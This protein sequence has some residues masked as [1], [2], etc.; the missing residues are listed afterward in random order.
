MAAPPSHHSSHP[1]QWAMTVAGH[2]LA[3]ALG[4]SCTAPASNTRAPGDFNAHNI[5][6][7]PLDE[8]ERNLNQLLHLVVQ[9]SSTRNWPDME[10]A[11]ADATQKLRL[12]LELNE[13]SISTAVDSYIQHKVDQLMRL[14]SFPPGLN[15]VY[16]RMMNRVFDSDDVDIY[17]EVLRLVSIVHRPLS[18]VELASLVDSLEDYAD[19]AASPEEIVVYFGHQP[20]KDFLLK[21]ESGIHPDGV[22]R[23][24]RAAALKSIQVM[25]RTPR[26]DISNLRAPGFPIEQVKPL[27]PDLL[28]PARYSRVYWVCRLADGAPSGQEQDSGLAYAFLK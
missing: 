10:D 22:A 19:D 24:H 12:C 3:L 6:I 25:S 15:A 16:A 2:R 20:A 8:C 26:R 13:E 7:E 4:R 11:L 23:E 27:G 9:A 28:A 5:C 14:L 18:L 17:R 21:D 1:A